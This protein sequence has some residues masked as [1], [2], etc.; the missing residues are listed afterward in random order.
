MT[1]TR[2][3]LA[4]VRAPLAALALAGTLYGALATHAG[5]AAYAPMSAPEYQ[6]LDEVNAD[7]AANGL[8]SL[9]ANDVLSGLARQ[10]SQQMLSSGV[11]SHY[12]AAGNLVFQGLLNAAGFPY[13]FAGENLAE[14]NY[15]W[16]QSMDQANTQLMNSPTH[17]ANI[18][19]T[20]FNE[21]GVGIAGP[22]PKGE[23]YYTQ[24]FAQT[25]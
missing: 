12:D 15:A 13:A 3:L 18:L 10:R 4:L 11:F 6:F 14:N 20:R 7:R 24:I 22:G 21:V 9:A 1:G 8:P 16:G 19:N 23:F 25:R 2:T 5:A 17:R